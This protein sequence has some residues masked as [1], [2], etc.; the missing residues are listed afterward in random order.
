MS[1]TQKPAKINNY[2]N[3]LSLNFQQ[4]FGHSN[5]GFASL[6]T[7]RYLATR[8][9]PDLDGEV[10]HE[11]VWVLGGEFVEEASPRRILDH[12]RQPRGS[13]RQCQLSVTHRACSEGVSQ[14][15]ARGLA[16]L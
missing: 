1:T 14:P 15:V 13:L 9:D 16:S 6:R 11:A 8:R 12:L 2:N 10:Q 7:R 5:F 3:I 4:N